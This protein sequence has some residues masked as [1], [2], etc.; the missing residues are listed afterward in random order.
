MKKLIL[1]LLSLALILSVATAFCDGSQ[2]FCPN[3]GH[4]NTENYCTQCG[5][6]RP[7][8][9]KWTCPGCGRTGNTENFCP[10]CGTKKPSGQASNV[11]TAGLKM[12]LSTRSGPGTN[13]DEP[14]TF[15]YK[16]NQWKSARVNVLGK[17]NA[18]VWWVLVDFDY[19]SM[20]RV[21]AWTGLKRVDVDLDLLPEINATGSGKVSA[22]NETYYG[23]GSNYAKAPEIYGT[24]S[25]TIYGRENGYVEVEYRVSDGTLRRCWVPEGYVSIK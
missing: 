24:K 3:C 16:D 18:G 17:K 5:R 8:D 4:S 19:G 12:Q 23:P 22:T 6:A 25:V 1:I 7:S 10:N 9:G 20:G 11:V 21:R 15:F 14:G 2:W 13:Y